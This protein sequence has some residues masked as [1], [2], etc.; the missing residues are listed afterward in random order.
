MFVFHVTEPRDREGQHITLPCSVLDW[1]V[2]AAHEHG[3]YT[4]TTSSVTLT[5]ACSSF[6]AACLLGDFRQPFFLSRQWRFGSHKVEISP[7]R[8]G[9]R[10]S[11]T[12]ALAPPNNPGILIPVRMYLLRHD[13]HLP[14]LILQFARVS[15]AQRP[16]RDFRSQITSESAETL[17]T[18]RLKPLGHWDHEVFEETEVGDKKALFND[19]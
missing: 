4:Q 10:R 16:R 17:F 15:S 2:Q 3:H 11:V 18:R 9:P 8:Q 1:V 14:F 19:R 5:T 13:I 12:A 7:L 6:Q